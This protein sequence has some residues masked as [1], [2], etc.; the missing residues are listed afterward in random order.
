MLGGSIRPGILGPL[1][2][3]SWLIPR[4]IPPMDGRGG[5][6]GRMTEGC[7]EIVPEDDTIVFADAPGPTEE[8]IADEGEMPNPPLPLFD[9]WD[10]T[11][12]LPGPPLRGLFGCTDFLKWRKFYMII[13]QYNR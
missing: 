13:D 5:G 1:E 8:L 11:I 7:R 10:G 6:A 3:V 2:G 12:E 9:N 4:P